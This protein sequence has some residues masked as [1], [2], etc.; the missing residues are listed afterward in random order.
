MSTLDLPV[1]NPNVGAT[2]MSNS[3][4][5]VRDLS[6]APLA[7][8]ASTLTCKTILPANLLL[9]TATLKEISLLTEANICGTEL[10]VSAISEALHAAQR[11]SRHLKS[12]CSKDSIVYL[13]ISFSSRNIYCHK[14]I[15]WG[16]E[17]IFLQGYSGG[18]LAT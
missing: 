3:P 1:S 16:P 12:S 2:V 14:N 15:I 18:E 11:Q 9:C 5:C 6:L 4:W 17:Y 10:L 13:S 7:Y 8:C